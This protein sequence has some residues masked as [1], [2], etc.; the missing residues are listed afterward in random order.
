MADCRRPRDLV[1]TCS[2]LKMKNEWKIIVE[3]S[4]RINLGSAIERIL[5]SSACSLPSNARRGGACI[6]T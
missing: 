5:T 3:E 1:A 6:I 4:K 2:A